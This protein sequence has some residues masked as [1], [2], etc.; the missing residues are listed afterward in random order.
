MTMPI[1]T[2]SL[3]P[4][5][6]RVKAFIDWDDVHVMPFIIGVDFPE[7]IK[8]FS[9]EGLSRFQLLSGRRVYHLTSMDRSLVRWSILGI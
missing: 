5:T 7:D 9:V 6:Y 3:D 4:H 2:F 8:F 1:V